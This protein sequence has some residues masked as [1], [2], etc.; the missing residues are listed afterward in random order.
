[1]PEVLIAKLFRFENAEYLKF[2]MEVREAPAFDF[3]SGSE[4]KTSGEEEDD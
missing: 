1:M 2:S 3:E 4:D